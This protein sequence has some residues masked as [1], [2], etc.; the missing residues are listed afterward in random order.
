MLMTLALNYIMLHRFH[1]SDPMKPVILISPTSPKYGDD[2]TFTCNVTLN[3]RN[4]IHTWYYNDRKIFAD[5]K[6][7]IITNVTKMNEGFYHCTTTSGGVS[8]SSD[9][10][11]LGE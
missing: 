11:M 5:K 7:Y 6:T 1:F 8:E 2:I 10:K 9:K 4:V 3:D